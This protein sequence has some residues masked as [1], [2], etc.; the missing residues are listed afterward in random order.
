MLNKVKMKQTLMVQKGA[1]RI[2]KKKKT[3]KS[4]PQ[5]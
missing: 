4:E 1:L 5:L 2:K 3:C